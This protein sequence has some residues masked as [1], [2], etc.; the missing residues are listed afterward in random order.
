MCTLWTFLLNLSM[1]NVPFPVLLSTLIRSRFQAKF[2]TL[3]IPIDFSILFA[4]EELYGTR[5]Q[6]GSFSLINVGSG[7]H[8]LRS[9]FLFFFSNPQMRHTLNSSVFPLYWLTLY[10]RVYWRG[11]EISKLQQ[12]TSYLPS[13]TSYTLWTGEQSYFLTEGLFLVNLVSML[14]V[15]PCKHVACSL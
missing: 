2:A 11:C 5:Y 1:L 14:Q 7:L 12:Q 9:F 10:C 6:S 13:W 8:C 4:V 15:V 3:L